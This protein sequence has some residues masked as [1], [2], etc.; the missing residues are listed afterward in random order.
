MSGGSCHISA[1][2]VFSGRAETIAH[3]AGIVFEVIKSGSAVFT[4]I[5]HSFF[6]KSLRVPSTRCALL[7]WNLPRRQEDEDQLNLNHQREMITLKIL[8]WDLLERQ[9]DEDQSN[10]TIKERGLFSRYFP[11]TCQKDRRM[12]TSRTSTIKERGL[13]F[14]YSPQ[15]C[16][17]GR[18][19]R[20]S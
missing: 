2:R 3:K 10:L 5:L 19:M 11:W 16:K 17:E 6:A 8:P 1:I 4:Q 20:T 18:G 14:R 12:M 9:E 7:P 15:T 13:C